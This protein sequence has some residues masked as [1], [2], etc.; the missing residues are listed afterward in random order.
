[1]PALFFMTMVGLA[2]GIVDAAFAQ[3]AHAPGQPTSNGKSK[4][5]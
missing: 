5:K 4:T 1:M 2:L 3:R